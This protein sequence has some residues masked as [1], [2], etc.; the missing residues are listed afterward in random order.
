MKVLF[1]AL[2]LTTSVSVLAN[3]RSQIALLKDSFKID[4]ANNG[5]AILRLTGNEATTAKLLDQFD[6]K[7]LGFSE[8]EAE[9]SR[10]IK[11]CKGM[12][13]TSPKPA[14]E[15]CSNTHAA[16]NFL[17]A[18]AYAYQ[19][20]NWSETTRNLAREKIHAYVAEVTRAKAFVEFSILSRILGHLPRRTEFLKLEEEFNQKLFAL[21]GGNPGTCG[22]MVPYY[23]ARQRLVEAYGPRL[24]ALLK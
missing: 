3:C 19:N 9:H 18:V 2:F 1:F 24:Q 7:S 10:L 14:R 20:S 4:Y 16:T 12:P 15:T 5:D 17:E 23:Q 6:P 13:N 21:P 8:S 22:G 11:V